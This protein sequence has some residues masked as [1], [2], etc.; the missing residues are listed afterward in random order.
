[1][2]VPCRCRLL[3]AAP[4]GKGKLDKWVKKIEA[5][6]SPRAPEVRAC[7]VRMRDS[8]TCCTLVGHASGAYIRILPP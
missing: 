6:K 3:S 7:L 4:A 2:H 8:A 1:M 5:K